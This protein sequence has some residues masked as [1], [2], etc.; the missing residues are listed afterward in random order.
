MKGTGGRYTIF[1]TGAT[2]EHRICIVTV[3]V[4]VVNVQTNIHDVQLEDILDGVPAQVFHRQIQDDPI[5]FLVRN[6]RNSKEDLSQ[7]L[8]QHLLDDQSDGGDTQWWNGHLEAVREGIVDF[9]KGTGESLCHLFLKG[10]LGVFE[11]LDFSGAR[12]AIV[13]CR[14]ERRHAGI[15]RKLQRHHVDRR[16]VQS[17]GHLHRELGGSET[18]SHL[19]IDGVRRNEG[20]ARGKAGTPLPLGFGRRPV[21][22]QHHTQYDTQ[23]D[24]G[25]HTP[26]REHHDAS[27]VLFFL[28]S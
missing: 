2:R 21:A 15:Q 28:C 26:D 17:V 18:R 22:K 27:F 5:H 23:N 8:L 19:G 16:T 14:V 9:N 20:N 25:D 7:L 1:F 12:A 11:L 3:A 13:R 10:V 24:D 6:H 4:D